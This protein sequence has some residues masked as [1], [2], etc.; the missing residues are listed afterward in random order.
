LLAVSIC[1]PVLALQDF[2]RF[3]AFSLKSPKMAFWN[4]LVWFCFQVVAIVTV[5]CFSDISPTTMIAAWGV[6]AFAGAIFGIGQFHAWPRL[7]R[8]TFQWAKKSISTA[9]WFAVASIIYG[10]GT[11]LTNALITVTLG[12]AA[13]GGIQSVNNLF[14][15]S[16]IIALTVQAIGL[17]AATKASSAGQ[18]HVLRRIAWQYAVAVGFTITIYA[19]ATLSVGEA[20][21]VFVF[22]PA[23]IPFSTIV[24][25][26]ALVTILSAW[27]SGAAATLIGSGSARRLAGI[28][29]LVTLTQASSVTAM[30]AAY[31]VE[32]AA[33]GIVAGSVVSFASLW[34]SCLFLTKSRGAVP[35]SKSP[36]PEV[37]ND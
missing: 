28:Q 4:D 9:G 29:A 3:A 23:F 26:A 19:V 30:S 8:A 12:R 11:Q 32:G 2:W 10:A 5:F 35:T 20:I 17:P 16:Q 6:G 34:W 1:L 15:P 7:T 25:P 36:D 13:L 27:S 33:W 14:A 24:L 37:G 21:L 22:G 18:A 31:G